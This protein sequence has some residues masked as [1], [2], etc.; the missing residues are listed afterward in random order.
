MHSTAC[1]LMCDSCKPG[2]TRT[3]PVV[4]LCARNRESFF[5]QDGAREYRFSPYRARRNALRSSIDQ[6]FF[7]R[8][9]GDS[10]LL[11]STD[12]SG[13]RLG[14]YDFLK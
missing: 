12:G 10:D 7:L 14:S 4:G 9:G 11:A 5:P 6:T 13:V 8:F 2:G 3:Y 1:L